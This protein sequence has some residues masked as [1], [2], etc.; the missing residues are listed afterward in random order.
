M[1]TVGFWNDY[2]NREEVDGVATVEVDENTER[3]AV[4]FVSELQ[5][6]KSTNFWANLSTAV[7]STPVPWVGEG[8]VSMSVYRRRQR[9]N[10]RSQTD[11]RRAC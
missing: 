6:W 11:I 10:G 1:T 5:K 9:K 2:S 7:P 3:V 8:H 4:F